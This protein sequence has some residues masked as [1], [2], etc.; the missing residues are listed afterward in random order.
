VAPQLTCSPGRGS[1]SPPALHVHGLSKTFGAT[2]ALDAV[3]LCVGA[4]QVHA[5]VGQNGSG[6]STLIKIL[7]GYHYPD[8]G[9]WIEVSGRPLP[10]GRP[11]D[12]RAAGTRFVHQDLALVRDETILDNMALG[13]GFP[14]RLGTIRRREA[15]RNARAQLARVSLDLDPETKIRQLSPAEQ[16]GVA[17]ARALG[18]EG[19]AVSLLVLDEPTATLPERDVDRLLDIVRATASRGIGVLYVT[20]RLDE[21]F[22]VSDAVTILR[23][24]RRVTSTATAAITRPELVAHLVGRQFEEAAGAR[25]SAPPAEGASLLNVARLQAGRLGPIDFTALAGEIV[26]FAGLT[27][28]G[29]EEIC[30]TVFG[31]RARRSGAVWVAGRALPGG[32]P[33]L[34]VARGV[35]YLPPDRRRQGG[36]MDMSARENLT[37]TGLGG[38]TRC[39]MVRRRLEIAEARKWFEIL[40]VRPRD[41]VNR[42]LGTFSGGNQQKILFAKWLRRSPRVLLLDEP[43]QG[44]D[45]AAKAELHAQIW[46]AAAAGTAV[47]VSSSDA[48]ELV[49]LCHRVIVLRDGQIAA[50]LTGRDL[51]TA[52]ISGAALGS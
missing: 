20:H 32:R 6:K 26:G 37:L 21:I 44:V 48:D 13:E 10:F 40:D 36:Q 23:D 15:A 39:L 7:S 34:A 33:D 29:R 31:A 9:G 8:A 19:D 42:S 27:G 49:G 17:I 30:A 3:D 2:K 47:I 45:V 51:A 18:R 50:H 1:T 11:G 16:T 38:V 12:S 24:G 22:K 52:A 35:A 4:G 46:A 25:S 41:G 43:T 28:S 5:L 14:T